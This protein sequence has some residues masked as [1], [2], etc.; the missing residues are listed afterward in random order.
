V[1]VDGSLTV[2]EGHTIGD[3]AEKAVR[4]LFQSAD[5]MAH[6]E[7]AGIDD[8]RLDDLVK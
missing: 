7:P 8:E 3:N 1:E 5:V 6:L 2:E 4:R